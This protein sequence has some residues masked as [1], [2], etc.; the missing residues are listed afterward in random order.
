M[1]LTLPLLKQAFGLILELLLKVF[2]RHAEH[3]NRLLLRNELAIDAEL[4]V[5][6]FL[7]LRILNFC[8]CLLEFMLLAPEP[9][10]L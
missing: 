9:K 2:L 10:D 5:R 3:F 7:A 1:D 8:V 4:L 6:Y